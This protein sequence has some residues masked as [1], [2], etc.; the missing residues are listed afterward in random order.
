LQARVQRRV[1]ALPTESRRI[2][3][4]ERLWEML[5]GALGFVRIVV[6]LVV[7]LL[8]M[9]YVLVQFPWT[10]AIGLRL[11]DYV[12]RPLAD[13]GHGFLAQ[14]PNLAFLVILFFATRY[15][16]SLARL[17]FEAV[18]RG[19][20]RLAGFEPEWSGPTYNLLRVA[21]IAFALVVA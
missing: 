4:I 8:F 6:V 18:A 21:I 15:A 11:F 12:A 2:L 10:R 19:S 14:I 13:M 3:R 16:L 1:E 17:Y 9:E 20:I 5:H 7:V